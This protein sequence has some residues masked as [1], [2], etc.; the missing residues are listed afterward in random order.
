MLYFWCKVVDWPAEQ[1]ASLC[2]M[3]G[4]HCLCE[5]IAEPLAFHYGTHANR[6]AVHH[7][8]RPSLAHFNCILRMFV[9]KTRCA[10]S[11][12]H[13]YLQN[14]PHMPWRNVTAGEGQNPSRALYHS[15]SLIQAEAKSSSSSLILFNNGKLHVEKQPWKYSRQRLSYHPP[16]AF[17]SHWDC[18]RC[19]ASCLPDV[20]NLLRLLQNFSGICMVLL[21]LS[22]LHS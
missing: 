17:I 1:S 12:R 4:T 3:P 5:R 10:V 7:L 16:R 2:L 20:V 19:G 11:Y 15:L 13:V 22:R 9:R 14:M 21:L 8:K 6:T 18:F